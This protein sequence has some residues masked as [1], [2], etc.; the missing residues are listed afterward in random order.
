MPIFKIHLGSSH[1]ASRL[2]YIEYSRT[3]SFGFSA[4]VRVSFC[5]WKRWGW[6]D[7]YIFSDPR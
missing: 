4:R 7:E 2:Q 1:I 5:N 6:L 3:M